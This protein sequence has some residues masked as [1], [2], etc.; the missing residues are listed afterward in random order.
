MIGAISYQKFHGTTDMYRSNFGHRRNIIVAKVINFHASVSICIQTRRNRLKASGAP[1]L[2]HF[3]VFQIL[4]Y[5]VGHAILGR[6]TIRQFSY[7]FPFVCGRSLDVPSSSWGGQWSASIL[8]KGQPSTIRQKG[9][10]KVAGGTVI[11]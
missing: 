1:Q 11:V 9:A 10:F 3:V 4:Y 7:E 6:W 2:S 8:W 5:Y